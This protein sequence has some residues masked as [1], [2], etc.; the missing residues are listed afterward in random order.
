[1]IYPPFSLK[2]R[3]ARK[4][5]GLSHLG[6]YER[7]VLRYGKGKLNVRS[8]TVKKNIQKLLPLLLRASPRQPL[9]RPRILMCRRCWW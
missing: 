7:R 5:G 1:M 2:D 4:Q 8:I 9:Q 6:L 3:P